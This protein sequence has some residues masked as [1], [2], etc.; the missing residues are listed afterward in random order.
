MEILGQARGFR[1]GPIRDMIVESIDFAFEQNSPDTRVLSF[2]NKYSFAKFD[3]KLRVIGFGKAAR[4][5]YLGVKKFFGSRISA[6]GVILPSLEGEKFDLPFLHGNHPLPG[7]ESIE[8]SIKLIELLNGI[9]RNDLVIVLVSGGGSSLFEIMRDGVKLDEYNETINC[10]MRN[11][12]NISELN[13]IRY[14]YSKTKGGGLLDYTYPAKVVSLIISDVPGDNI[15][16]IA[17]GPTSRPP[18]KLLIEQTLA[19]YGKSCTL[20]EMVEKPSIVTYEAENYVILRNS[21]F[22]RSIIQKI[23]DHGIRGIDLGSE[24]EG[25]TQSVAKLLV[26]RMRSEYRKANDPVIVVG[27]GETSTKRVGQGKGG[28]NL[29]LALRVSLLMERNEEF[30]FGSIGTDGMDGS[31]N[32]MGAIVD[33]ETLK[34]LDRKFVLESLSKSESLEPLIMSQDV[35]FTGFTGTNVSDIFVGYYSGTV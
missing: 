35:L 11:G 3:G 5:M 34:M 22:V 4:G 7:N 27:G 26:D 20:P 2:L 29:E 18:E 23:R 9:T 6:A 14:L 33:G 16:T 30:T 28:R 31:S 12:A 10:M 21:D 17:S 24:I 19:K 25:D 32:A 13:A 8:S 15:E 1:G